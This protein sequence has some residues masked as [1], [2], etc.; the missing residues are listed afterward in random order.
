MENPKY[1]AIKKESETGRVYTVYIETDEDLASH[2]N[3]TVKLTEHEILS[4]TNV[5]P[6]V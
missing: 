3:A 6:E 4:V 1:I 5:R 2:I